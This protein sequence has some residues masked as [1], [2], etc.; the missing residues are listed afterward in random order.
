[1][2]DSRYFQNTDHGPALCK[3]PDYELFTVASMIQ[4][5]EAMIEQGQPEWETVRRILEAAR[6]KVCVLA[7]AFMDEEHVGETESEGA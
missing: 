7:E 4:G 1:M 5:A 2:A 6:A 3:S